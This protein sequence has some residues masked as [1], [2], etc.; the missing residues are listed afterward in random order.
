M[1]G[2]LLLRG[3]DV[4]GLANAGAQAPF[5]VALAAGRID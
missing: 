5:P 1:G 2:K 4:G 3:A